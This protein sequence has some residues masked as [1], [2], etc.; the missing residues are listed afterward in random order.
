MSSEPVYLYA[1]LLDVLGYRQL[2]EE[3]R[4]NAS[5]DFKENLN[6]ALRIFEELNDAIFK[7]Q[8]ISDT[9]IITC[10]H[11][12]HF[13]EFL[14]I[15]KRVFLSFLSNNLF[16]RGAVAYSRHYQNNHMTY[17]HAVAR[18]YEL[19]QHF[20]VYPRIVIDENIIEMYKVGSDLT[21]IWSRGIICREN[22]S[23]FLEIVDPY[24]WDE[25]Y[26]LASRLFKSNEN[27]LKKNEAAYM[28][29]LRFQ[30]Y[31]LSSQ[32]APETAKP[33]IPQ[34]ARFP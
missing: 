21:D 18:A 19:E 34:I 28:K 20:A 31:L 6:C 32:F 1:A 25:V 4:K 9:I 7:V 24:N 10:T 8:A 17:S 2:L 15:L 3:D 13:L 23:Y 22:G 30:W 33:Y 16:V 12:S 29:H 11:H 5:L 27:L 26:L 14:D